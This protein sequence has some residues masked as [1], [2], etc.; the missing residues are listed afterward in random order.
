MEWR[1]GFQRHLW[2]LPCVALV[3]CER[4]PVYVPD[5]DQRMQYLAEYYPSLKTIHDQLIFESLNCWR[6][7]RDLKKKRSTFQEKET[8][9]IVSAKI[10]EIEEQKAS[11]ELHVKRIHAEAEKGIAYRMFEKIDGGAADRAGEISDRATSVLHDKI[12][13]SRKKRYL[14]SFQFRCVSQFQYHELLAEPLANIIQ[15]IEW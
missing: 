3:S 15:N 2:A 5:S 12:P 8:V 13:V 14:I 9:E 6:N 11:L 7:V 1:I 4:A 10:K